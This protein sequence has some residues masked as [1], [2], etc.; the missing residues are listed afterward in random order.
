M[1]QSNVHEQPEGTEESLGQKLSECSE[2]KQP[3]VTV[4]PM[5]LQENGILFQINR[6]ILHPLGMQIRINDGKIDDMIPP[7]VLVV[8]SRTP[9][10]MPLK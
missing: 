1:D 8:T 10:E 3:S 7:D 5:S 9:L 4:S 6:Q 2:T